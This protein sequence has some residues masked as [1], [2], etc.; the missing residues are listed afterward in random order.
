MLETKSVIF[1]GCS[2]VPIS[3]YLKAL[4]IARVLSEQLTPD[5]R[6]FWNED[7]SFSVRSTAEKEEIE[8]FL[9]NE[10]RPS[11]LFDP[12][13]GGSG[14]F[15]RKDKKTGKRTK[16]TKATKAVDAVISSHSERLA[17][18]SRL[19]TMI[20]DI[21][22]NSGMESAP[23]DDEKKELMM[24]LRASLPDEAL[25]W[26]DASVIISGQSPKYPALMG[27]GGNDG[28][29][30]FANNFYQRLRE[31]FDFD[32]GEPS[33]GS[34]SWLE[35][36]L[37]GK[38]TSGLVRKVA[39]GQFNPGMTGGVNATAGFEDDSIVNPWE[40]V[41]MLEGALVFSAS[42]SRRMNASGIDRFSYPFTVRPV[43]AGYGSSSSHEDI[44]SEMWLPV[45]N[46]AASFG[47]I[48]S[49]FAEGRA[50]V[51]ARNARDGLDFA[52][53]TASMGVDRG[54]GKFHRYSFMLRNGR[55]YFATHLGGFDVHMDRKVELLDEVKPWLDRLRS[56]S[57]D[58]PGS[59]LSSVRKLESAMMELCSTG[60]RLSLYR[61]FLET[62]RAERT[63][64]NSG[65]WKDKPYIAPLT[66]RSSE[67]LEESYD[68]SP[69]FRLAASISS[70]WS[71]ASSSIRYLME[72]LS[73]SPGYLNFDSANRVR[74]IWHGPLSGSLNRTLSRFLVE[75]ESRDV[76][77]YPLRSSVPARLSDIVLFI[78]G[79][80]NDEKIRELVESLVLMDWR[81]VTDRIP[82]NTRK[83]SGAIPPAAWCLMKLDH[84]QHP[85]YD[86]H[87]PVDRSIHRLAASGNLNEA[88]KRSSIRLR[89]NGL[90]PVFSS[91]TG[92]RKLSRRMA[93]ALLF[94]ISR[95]D[96]YRIAGQTV[97]ADS[98][99]TAGK[100][101]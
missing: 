82:W 69:E 36:A 61:L 86:I 3:S 95:T 93:A 8:D 26:L 39:I 18:C 70:C 23:S 4:G 43:R 41:L 19:L 99:E 33:P 56:A 90:V 100:E 12:W 62:G 71:K 1:R 2:P 73:R 32:T 65:I 53:A 27:T 52:R 78:N 44:R 76:K 31:L 25:D 9:L 58:G 55:S 89:G 75:A 88:V 35:S 16:P 6:C 84:L 97:T 24:I 47:E 57:S 51:G 15:K 30:D 59:V 64:V 48:K 85:P 77:G 72:P 60:S 101:I 80:V 63:A 67:W 13:N 21:L 94:P 50:T 98:L 11:P 92:S 29:L 17:D 34:S 5:L 7:E 96:T 49:L 38:T 28:N 45:W 83:S 10:Y 40:Y 87:I 54:I 74:S 22:S 81:R 42:A 66:L 91:L 46:T 20:E 14:F 68:G 79:R 37:Y